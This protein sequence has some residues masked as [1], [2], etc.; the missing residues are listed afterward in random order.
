MRFNGFLEPPTPPSFNGIPSSTINGLL[1]RPKEPFPRI[2]IVCPSPGAPLPE[3]TET[4][5][6]LPL[7]N[8]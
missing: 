7:I 4:P 8:C 1:E 2:L 6:I 3:V 5:A